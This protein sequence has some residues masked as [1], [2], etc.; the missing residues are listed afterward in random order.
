M[1]FGSMYGAARSAV[2][3]GT[4]NPDYA[5]P[6]AALDMVTEALEIDQKFFNLFVEHDFLEAAAMTDV[7]LESTLIAVD[8][9][10]ISDAWGKILE[11]LKKIKD[12]IVSIFKAAS[13]K[14]GAF[15]RKDNEALVRKYQKQYDNSD[16]SIEIKG[17]CEQINAP[18]TL[19]DGF[20]PDLTFGGIGIGTAWRAGSADKAEEEA[21]AEIK[22][23]E[24]TM[25]DFTVSK[26]LKN[27]D[28]V[29]KSSAVGESGK[30]NWKSL[31]FKQPKDIKANK[32]SSFILDSLKNEQAAIRDINDVKKVLEESVNAMD[33][34]IKDHRESINDKISG[35][36]ELANAQRQVESKKVDAARSICTATNTAVAKISSASLEAI[37]F[38]IKQCRAAFIKIASK[39][40]PSAPKD[41]SVELLE[42]MLDADE[43]EVDSFFDQYSYD[44]DELMA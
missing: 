36:D 23:I 19:A 32:I 37:K 14:I 33:K 40:A 34:S 9:N 15:F 7:T 25:K 17:F 35:N 29:T 11:F 30:V 1:V 24:S 41:E 6:T 21:K 26:L 2:S 42:A 44:M 10:F 22:K 18:K 12:K 20:Q 5:T 27:S 4:F 3:K 38:N 13:V 31:L 28:G 8:E 39:G 16:L 43:Y